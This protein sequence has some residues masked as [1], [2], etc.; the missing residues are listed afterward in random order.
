MKT[1]DENPGGKDA[2]SH[3]TRINT[4]DSNRIIIS[5]LSSNRIFL[6]ITLNY[7][8][9]VDYDYN[10]NY[11]YNYNYDYDYNYDLNIGY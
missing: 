4:T 1:P 10:Y 6:T 11:N 5:G 9:D 3:S 8:L 2:S 7:D